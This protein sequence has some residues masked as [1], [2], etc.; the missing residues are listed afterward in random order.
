MCLGLGLTP[1]GADVAQTVF[2]F[3]RAVDDGVA[4]V[5]D[6]VTLR[7]PQLTTAEV[8][9]H[10]VMSTERMPRQPALQLIKVT[11]ILEIVSLSEVHLST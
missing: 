7:E 10:S 4:G 3:G 2:P 11:D 5:V 8:I 1:A 6:G 9:R